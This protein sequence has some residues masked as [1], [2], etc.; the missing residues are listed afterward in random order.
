MIRTFVDSGVLIAAAKADHTAAEPAL[1]LLEH[2]DRRM[3]T[4]VFVRLEVYPK[5]GFHGYALQRAFLNE[6]F[7]DPALEWA[8]DLNGLI[9]R[10]ISESER[11]GLAAMDALHAA[12]ALLLG[13]GEFVTTEKAGKPIY[14]V[15]GFQVLHISTFHQT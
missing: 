10:A 8:R 7:M 12:A 1:R 5:T 4:S 6:Y 2:P 14:R 13:A 15:E 9:N 3:L 11:H